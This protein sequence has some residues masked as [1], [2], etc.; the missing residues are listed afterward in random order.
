MDDKF[1]IEDIILT[2]DELEFILPLRDNF[3]SFE[4]PNR[5][6]VYHREEVKD[7]SKLSLFLEK[8]K[9]KFSLLVLDT[10]TQLNLLGI[11]INH[12]DS[13]ETQREDYHVDDSEFTSITFLD[14]DFEGGD[15]EISK[16]GNKKIIKP[17]L[18][19]TV[20]FRGGEFPHRVLPVTSGNRHTLVTFWDKKSK[21]QNSLF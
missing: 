6:N 8:S 11:W 20:F 4:S 18:G 13:S 21:K 14:D 2:E 17:K 19:R 15:L 5:N 16:H 12:I 10:N 9:E 7:F 1:I 3:K